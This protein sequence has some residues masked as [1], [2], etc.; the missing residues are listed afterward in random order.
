VLDVPLALGCVLVRLTAAL[1]PPAISD[2]PETAAKLQK[3]WRV[4]APHR[5]FDF[6]PHV[7]TYALVSLLNKGLVYEDFQRQYAD[8]TRQVCFYFILP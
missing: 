8:E 6:A 5:Q 4:H 3:E 7:N 1:R 2:Y